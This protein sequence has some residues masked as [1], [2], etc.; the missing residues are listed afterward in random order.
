MPTCRL[1]A[2][3]PACVNTSDARMHARLAPSA[4]PTSLRSPA[5]F[6]FLNALAMPGSTTSMYFI[7]S[8]T[9]PRMPP[10]STLRYVT[11]PLDGS[12]GGGMYREIL[13]SESCLITSML[14]ISLI[15][16]RLCT[17]FI[18]MTL[19]PSSE[20]FTSWRM[21]PSPRITAPVERSILPS[22]SAASAAWA[23]SNGSVAISTSG[24][25]SRPSP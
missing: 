24:I 20:T 22:A 13:L 15:I 2:S 25:P 10:A 4:R 9:G 19:P 18:S 3:H 11:G 1:A 5:R 17:P 6:Q 8:S 21:V 23:G 14:T 16:P 12:S 7:P